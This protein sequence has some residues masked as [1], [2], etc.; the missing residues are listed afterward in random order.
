MSDTTINPDAPDDVNDGVIDDEHDDSAIEVEFP[1]VPTEA[2]LLYAPTTEVELP[3][4]VIAG[5]PNV[6]KSTLL[7][8]VV[9]RR[10]AIVEERPGVTR[11]RFE[12]ESDWRGRRFLLVDTGGITD[13]GDQLDRKVTAQTL[14]AFD[15]ADL[16]L[17]VLDAVTGPTAEDEVVAHLLRR[18][19]P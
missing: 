4:V 2:A 10:V 16:I 8:R 3:R 9:G 13:R 1:D 5:R 7:N 12:M 18:H 14:R 6:G 11:D 15:D 19:T 17:W